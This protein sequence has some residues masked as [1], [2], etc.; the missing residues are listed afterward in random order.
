MSDA[1]F[2]EVG[3][4]NPKKP[5]KYGD[6]KQYAV[7][8]E[9][10][11]KGLFG[12]YRFLSNFHL[13]E[14]EYDDDMYPSTENAYQAAKLIKEHRNALMVCSPS[15]SK[16]EWKKYPLL[17]ASPELWDARKL[18]V[19]T[20]ITLDKYRRH[21][22]LRDRLLATDQRY[23]EETNHWNDSFYG[24]DIRIGGRNELGKLLMNVRQ[25][26]RVRPL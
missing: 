15:D 21:T 16:K 19:M 13:A 10:N 9:K 2:N 25:F 18:K 7:H 24:V 26:F 6:W 20:Y 3:V 11:I 12:E 8:D 14:V 5:Y 23:I 4:T 1:M 22:H 17:D